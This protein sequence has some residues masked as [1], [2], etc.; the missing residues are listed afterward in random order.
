MVAPRPNAAT[1]S[2]SHCAAPVRIFSDASSN[3][4]ANIACAI[5]VPTMP[6]AI[7]AA[8]Y[9]AASRG[10]SS[11]LRANTRVTA[12]LKCAPE[13]GPKIVMRTTSIAPVGSVLPSSASAT[14]LVRVSAMMPEPTTVATNSAVPSASAASR[15]G[16]SNSGISCL[17]PAECC[18][19]HT[20]NIAQLPRERQ[21]IDASHRQACEDGDPVIEKAVRF[22][23][24]RFLR[25]V[26]ALDFGRVFDAPMRGHRLARPNR[27]GFAG[28]IV[29]D[30]KDKIHHWRIGTRELF[31]T[32]RAQI[33]RGIIEAFENLDR[34]RI[35][36]A[37]RLAAG[38]ERAEA[39]PTL[40]P[41]DRVRP[42]RTS[43]VSC[44][45]E[46]DVVDELRHGPFSLALADNTA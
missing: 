23:E 6:P 40:F 2:A 39:P 20:A 1:A 42:D 9:D 44:A 27:A 14:S 35:H 45:Q 8:T 33:V 41:Q 12:G 24:R 34:E 19:V 21:L 26:G 7:C 31:P 28:R 37:L 11:R 30:R 13:M 16:R 22:N 32:L 18:P 43:A 46:Q 3:G 29:A 4:R 25:D 38:R 10:V 5:M 15:R 17:L 36:G